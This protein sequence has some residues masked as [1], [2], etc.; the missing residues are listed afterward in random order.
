M[1]DTS[2]D[3]GFRVMNKTD[4]DVAHKLP[5]DNY[6][7]RRVLCQRPPGGEAPTLA[8]RLEKASCFRYHHFLPRLLQ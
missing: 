1:S 8:W 5:V 7:R 4:T 2:L 3:D 6:N